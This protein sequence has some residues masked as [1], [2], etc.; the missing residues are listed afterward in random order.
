MKCLNIFPAIPDDMLE[1]DEEE[2]EIFD[3]EEEIFD[4]DA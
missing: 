2:E 1:E 3:E 4:E